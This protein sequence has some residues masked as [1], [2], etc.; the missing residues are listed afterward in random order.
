MNNVSP[1][2]L[3]K[4]LQLN[5]QYN[6]DRTLTIINSYVGFR[7]HYALIIRKEDFEVLKKWEGFY[8]SKNNIPKYKGY[9]VKIIN[10]KQ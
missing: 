2:S 7:C 6:F 8:Y 9:E 3:T 1:I 5:D 10:G 4:A